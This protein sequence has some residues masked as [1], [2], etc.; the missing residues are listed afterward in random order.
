MATESATPDETPSSLPRS[1]HLEILDELESTAR[2][3][4]AASSPQSSSS[5]HHPVGAPVDEDGSSWSLAQDADLAVFLQEF[6]L[7]VQRRAAEVARSAEA[8]GGKVRRTSAEVRTARLEFTLL[9][10]EKFVEQVV[11]EDDKDGVRELEDAKEDRDGNERRD[12]DARTEGEE[13]AAIADGLEALSVFFDPATMSSNDGGGGAAVADS[14]HYFG[15]DGDDSCH[16]YESHPGDVYNQRPLP[17]VAGSR[18]FMESADAGLGEEEDG[19][20]EA[21]ADEAEE[22]FVVSGEASFR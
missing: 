6:S 10:N 3:W 22:R 12:D 4:A 17:F 19:S 15:L 13:D 16:F 11:E 8:L 18:E 9:T 21:L 14:D 5:P 20:G 7:H 1:R 2:Q